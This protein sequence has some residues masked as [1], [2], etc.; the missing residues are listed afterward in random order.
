M[1]KNYIVLDRDSGSTSDFVVHEPAKDLVIVRNTWTSGFEE[2]AVDADGLAVFRYKYWYM[3]G[4]KKVVIPHSSI[5]GLMDL[6]D[7]MRIHRGDD[8]TGDRVILDTSKGK[9][10]GPS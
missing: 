2:L 3:K 5:F 10:C 6:I 9:K 7:V 1:S 8:F 4:V